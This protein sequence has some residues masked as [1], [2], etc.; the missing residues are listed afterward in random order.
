MLKLRHLFGEAETG[1]GESNIP[2]DALLMGKRTKVKLG[3]Y[4]KC[5]PERNL[6]RDIGTKSANL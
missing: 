3:H 6:R 5:L 1:F 2:F 4:I